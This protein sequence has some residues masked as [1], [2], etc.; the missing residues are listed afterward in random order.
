MLFVILDLFSNNINDSL[1]RKLFH[2]KETFEL[3][4]WQDVFR[5]TLTGVIHHLYGQKMQTGV[6]ANEN[7]VNDTIIATKLYSHHKTFPFS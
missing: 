6:P 5:F 4:E 1:S 7:E 2:L 3:W